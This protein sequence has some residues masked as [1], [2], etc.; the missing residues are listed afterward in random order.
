MGSINYRVMIVTCSAEKA[1]DL[2]HE[3]FQIM[4]KELSSARESHADAALLTS[5]VVSDVF[6]TPINGDTAMIFIKPTGSKEGWAPAEAWK[7]ATRKIEAH[8]E[9]TPGAIWA[10]FSMGGDN[11]DIGMI[12]SKYSKRG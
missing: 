9:K 6:I 2:R 5:A 11:D 3:F 12:R 7:L 4:F 10:L 1:A 8:C